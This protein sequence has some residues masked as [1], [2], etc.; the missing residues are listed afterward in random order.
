MA[1]RRKSRSDNEGPQLIIADGQLK[2]LEKLKINFDETKSAPKKVNNN[3]GPPNLGKAVRLKVPDFSDPN[4]PRT[5]LEVVFP[6]F[7]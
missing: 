6:L 7:L 1:A 4:R 5:C 2:I 3:N